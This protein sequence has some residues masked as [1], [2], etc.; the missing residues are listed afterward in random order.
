LKTNSSELRLQRPT[1]AEIDLD[2][3]HSNYRRIRKAAP[4]SQVLAVVKSDAYG[5]GAAI[6][7]KELQESGVVFFATA[8]I[9]EGIL[10]RKNGITGSIMIL[11]GVTPQ[12]IPLL[13]DLDLTPV[14]YN[15]EV[16]FA[17]QAFS[18]LHS[19]KIRIHVKVDTGMGRLG[20]SPEDASQILQK[21][22]PNIEIDGLLT[23]LACSDIPEDAHTHEQLR[24]FQQ[25]VDAYQDKIPHIHAANSGAI[26]QYPESHYGL[27]RPGILL[28]G[29]SPLIEPSDFTPILSLK[30]KIILLHWIK[31]GD[32]IGYGRTFTA[33]RDS[34]I[35]TVPIGYSDGLRRTLSNQLE[36][37]VRG[38]LCRVAGTISMDLCML[39]VTDLSKE[40]Q[41]Y[42]VATFIGPMTT[43]W[44]W[45]KLLDTIPYEIT[46]LIGARVPRVYLKQ[47]E[48]HDI[49]YP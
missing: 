43:A 31:K 15:H 23:H 5:H 12:Q 1:W 8:T 17:L 13:L 16:L 48:V 2:A 4:H 37:E 35:A 45:A 21:N 22:Y 10:L 28:Y 36:V 32:T 29:I 24:R 26:L 33:D 44:D 30:S 19:K 39:D 11:G 49:Y 14:V 41:L 34:L 6:V 38:R 40:V 47:G 7:S 27:V 46:C 18:E 20:F 25:L 9:E 42:D 3:L